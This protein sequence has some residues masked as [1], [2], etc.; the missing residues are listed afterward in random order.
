MMEYPTPS[1][2]PITSCPASPPPV[3]SLGG[4]TRPEPESP[5]APSKASSLPATATTNRKRKLTPPG[6]STHHTFLSATFQL[7]IYPL[8]FADPKSLILVQRPAKIAARP[9]RAAAAASS[10]I[11]AEAIVQSDEPKST[12]SSTGVPSGNSGSTGE[13][14]LIQ[15][16]VPVDFD[17]AP[18]MDTAGAPHVIW[19]KGIH[20]RT[21][22]VLLHRI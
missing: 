21:L 22:S 13:R 10:F 11:L 19:K 3:P 18:Y 14:K 15:A 6:K 12:A 5:V 17:M 16:P 4:R 1:T 2:S 20:C 7:D 9:V 8:Y